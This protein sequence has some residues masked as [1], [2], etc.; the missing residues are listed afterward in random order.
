MRF[1]CGDRIT[2]ADFALGALLFSV[3]L[4]EHNPNHL[5]FSVILENGKY[6]HVDKYC[7]NI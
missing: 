7:E 2:I 3:F 1:I 4:N 5:L 6:P